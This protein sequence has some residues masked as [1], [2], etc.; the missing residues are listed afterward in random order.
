MYEFFSAHEFWCEAN[1]YK[2][3]FDAPTRERNAELKAKYGG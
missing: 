1:G 2:T 3:K